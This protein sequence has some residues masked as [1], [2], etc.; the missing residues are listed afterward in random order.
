MSSEKHQ[1][2]PEMAVRSSSIKKEESNEDVP[3]QEDAVFGEITNKG[4]N[5]R[6]VRV[7]R[8]SMALL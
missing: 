4:P 1:Y 8:S 2:D 5:Y 3:V 7:P 6:N